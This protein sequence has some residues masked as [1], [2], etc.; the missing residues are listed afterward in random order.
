MIESND[1]NN[2]NENDS[3]KG[4]KCGRTKGFEIESNIDVRIQGSVAKLKNILFIFLLGNI[5]YAIP[6]RRSSPNF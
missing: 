3:G 2:E 1:K 6:G 5:L 4:S